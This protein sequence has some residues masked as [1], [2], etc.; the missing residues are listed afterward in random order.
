MP[1]VVPSAHWIN[2]KIKDNTMF[3]DRYTFGLVGSE[4]HCGKG[5]LD[6]VG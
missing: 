3:L 6:G 1:A 5:E 4:P 2:L